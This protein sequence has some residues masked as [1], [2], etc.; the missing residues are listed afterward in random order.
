[1]V[2]GAGKGS[3]SIPGLSFGPFTFEG[4]FEAC[5]LQKLQTL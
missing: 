4:D 1:M 3:G 2:G 5:G